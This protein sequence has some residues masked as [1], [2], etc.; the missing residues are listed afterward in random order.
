MFYTQEMLRQRIFRSI[1]TTIPHI[2]SALKFFVHCIMN[3]DFIQDFKLATISNF[4]YGDIFTYVHALQGDGENYII[5][6]LVI[7]TPY[8]ILCGW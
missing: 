8:R 7:C 2:L 6:S 4:H 3:Y 1:T 5:R